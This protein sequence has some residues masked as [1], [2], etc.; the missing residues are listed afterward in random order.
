MSFASAAGFVKRLCES[1]STRILSSFADSASPKRLLLVVGN[2]E[3]ADPD[4]TATGADAAKQR[5]TS[6]GGGAAMQGGG[7]GPGDNTG[8]ALESSFDSA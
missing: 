4:T 2:G 5:V 8:V 6:A 3:T 7:A 1:A